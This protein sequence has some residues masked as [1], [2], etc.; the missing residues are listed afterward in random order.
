M[1]GRLVC[2]RWVVPRRPLASHGERL[3]HAGPSA[4]SAGN[5]RWKAH[6]LLWGRALNAPNPLSHSAE[7][8]QSSMHVPCPRLQ[9]NTRLA[10]IPCHGKRMRRVPDAS[11]MGAT[12]FLRWTSDLH[13]TRRRFC[14]AVRPEP[15]EGA[16]CGVIRFR[17][18]SPQSHGRTK[19]AGHQGAGARN[20]I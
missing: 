15:G 18:L 17:H 8:K 2:S 13:I 16:E 20:A 5:E 7:S 14:S 3:A 12:P 6:C 19:T 10:M 1:P 11:K 9:S 4:D